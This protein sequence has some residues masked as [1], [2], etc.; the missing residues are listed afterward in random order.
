MDVLEV[1]DPEAGPWL[2]R[3]AP[4]LHLLIGDSIARD[5]GLRSRLP[6]DEFLSLARGGATWK[7]TARDLEDIIARWTTK[8]AEEGRRLGDAVIWLT[9]NDVYSRLTL[10]SS[11]S[12]ETLEETGRLA[13]DVC[14]RLLEKGRVTVLGPLPRMSGEISGSRWETTASYHLERRLKHSL[15]PAVRLVPLGR[16]LLRRAGGRY[17]VVQECATSF[18]HDGV[19]LTAEG[20]AR[21]ADALQ[22]PIWISL[23]AAFK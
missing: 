19:H 6:P 5:S 23:T 12:P 21:V 2:D 17:C 22:L 18:R 16:Q 13:A 11:F 14:R 10:L 15:P 3:Q 20:Y 7:S 4:P 9:G 1:S 8:A